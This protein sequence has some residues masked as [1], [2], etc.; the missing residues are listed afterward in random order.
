M[1]DILHEYIYG[2]DSRALCRMYSFVAQQVCAVLIDGKE[3]CCYD[4]GQ[5]TNFHY[6]QALKYEY[7][8][9]NPREEQQ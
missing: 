6:E 8:S 2:C 4:N 3:V 7:P 9:G 5:F 1:R